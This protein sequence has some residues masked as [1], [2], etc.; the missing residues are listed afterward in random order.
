VTETVGVAI[1]EFWVGASDPGVGKGIAVPV[2]IVGTNVVVS[3]PLAGIAAGA[4]QF[5][6]RVQDTAGNWSAGANTTVTVMKPNAIFS[7]NFET[8]TAAWSSSVGNA[9]TS[10]PAT[11]VSAIEPGSTKGLQVALPTAGTNRLAYVTDA[12]PS[13]ETGYHARF[14]FNRNT[15]TSGTNIGNAVTIF[16]TRTGT[17]GQVFAVQFRMNGPQAQLRTVI[18][19]STGLV[20]GAW[21]NLAPGQHIL[22]VDWIAATAGSVVLRIDG[23]TAQT[24]TGNTNVQRVETALLGATA[25]VTGTGGANPSGTA[26][27]DSFLST[28]NTLP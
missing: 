27:F 1:A 24:Q 26:Y 22:Q 16:E 18:R 3:V 2:S 11:L 19:K 7:D 6:L 28:R 10:G 15:L 5:N 20:T 13:A 14:T 9:S 4:Q 8:T 12:T 21:V 25:G 23:A 17:N